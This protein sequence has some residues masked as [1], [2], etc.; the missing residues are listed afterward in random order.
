[1]EAENVGA[2]CDRFNNWF[3]VSVCLLIYECVQEVAKHERGV[4]VKKG[5][6]QVQIQIPEFL[7]TS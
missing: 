6:C 7:A 1:M 5:H 3:M 2:L 4:R